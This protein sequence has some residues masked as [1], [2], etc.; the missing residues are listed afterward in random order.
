MTHV[1]IVLLSILDKV[2]KET[3]LKSAV[4]VE[5]LF[6]NKIKIRRIKG[7]YVRI[8]SVSSSCGRSL[9]QR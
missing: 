8:E 2:K 5:K 4:V 1:S 6:G 9:S 3:Q 7:P